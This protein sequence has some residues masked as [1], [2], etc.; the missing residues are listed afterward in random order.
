MLLDLMNLGLIEASSFQREDAESAE[1]DDSSP[2]ESGASENENTSPGNAS[3]GADASNINP[4]SQGQNKRS[5]KAHLGL[6][7]LLGL[8]GGT[9]LAAGCVSPRRVGAAM[10]TVSSGAQ[11]LFSKVTGATTAGAGSVTSAVSNWWPAFCDEVPAAYGAAWEGVKSTTWGKNIGAWGSTIKTSAVGTKVGAVLG[12]PVAAFKSL[13]GGCMAAGFAGAGAWTAA[14]PGFLGMGLLW[15][16]YH[17]TIGKSISNIGAVK[18]GDK[19]IVIPKKMTGK[20]KK[21][22][23]NLTFAGGNVFAALSILAAGACTPMA[24]AWATPFIVGAIKR[25][26]R[27][28]QIHPRGSYKNNHPGRYA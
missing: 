28:P 27:I 5:G 15:A 8:G 17:K 2:T 11:G 18:N 25:V 14:I 24:L 12:V 3:T 9:V 6:L 16:G 4:S 21:D 19:K 23:T 1:S 7:E 22:V 13:F 10:G 26:R 20:I